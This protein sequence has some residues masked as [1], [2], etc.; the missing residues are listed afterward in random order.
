M[1]YRL[2]PDVPAGDWICLFNNTI[3]A[4]PALGEEPNALVRWLQEKILKVKWIYEPFS[5]FE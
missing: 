4:R 1:D 5:L 2:P 3:I